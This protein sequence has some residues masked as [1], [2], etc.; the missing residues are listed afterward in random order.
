MAKSN[1]SKTSSTA[2]EMKPDTEFKRK[3]RGEWRNKLGYRI[4]KTVEVSGVSVPARYYAC[5]RCQRPGFEWWEFAHHRRPYKT[6]KAAVAACEF[7]H[8]IWSAFVQLSHASG[9]R[10]NRL[11]TL[12]ARLSLQAVPVW[13][14][15]VA[16]PCYLLTLNPCV[17]VRTST[18]SSRGS[19]EARAISANTLANTP[20]PAVGA[21]EGSLTQTIGEG[22]STAP[23]AKEPVAAKPRSSKQ[24]TRKQFVGGAKTL[25]RGA[26]GRNSGKQPSKSSRKR[27][28]KS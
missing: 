8:K 11:A 3:K 23:T 13:V 4:T 17:P 10:T 22:T 15:K 26:K 6:F 20:A 27:K 24:P 12:K 25:K 19:L 9:S 16:E 5:V 7:N 2:S 18:T 21:V 14:T 1:V 28:D